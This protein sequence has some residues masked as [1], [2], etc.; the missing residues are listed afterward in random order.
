LN[1]IRVMPAKGLDVM[2]IPPLS[3]TPLAPAART[4]GAGIVVR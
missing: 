1:L 3:V 4:V 2:N